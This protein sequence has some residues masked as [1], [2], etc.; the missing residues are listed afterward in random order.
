M[1]FS[2]V[3]IRRVQ[4]FSF[5]SFVSFGSPQRRP[6]G[7]FVSFEP[8]R[9]VSFRPSRSFRLVYRSFPYSSCAPRLV[10]SLV[11]CVALCSSSFTSSLFLLILFLINNFPFQQVSHS[12][13]EVLLPVGLRA[14]GGLLIRVTHRLTYRLTRLAKQAADHP[15]MVSHSPGSRSRGLVTRSSSEFGHGL[16]LRHGKSCWEFQLPLSNSCYVILHN[17]CMFMY[18]RNT[19]ARIIGYWFFDVFIF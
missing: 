2:S 8:F 4:S 6:L 3:V 18:D 16:H 1:C 9:F 10:I 15:S 11:S 17:L 14:G 19:I 12:S 7:R 13:C 5:V